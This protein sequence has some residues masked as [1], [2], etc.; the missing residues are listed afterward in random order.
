MYLVTAANKTIERTKEMKNWQKN[1]TKTNN[2]VRTKCHTN[3]SN[4]PL[5]MISITDFTVNMPLTYIQFDN[6]ELFFQMISNRSNTFCRWIKLK[7]RTRDRHKHQTEME[8]CQTYYRITWSLNFLRSRF[9]GVN[10]IN[11]F[12]CNFYPPPPD[13]DSAKSCLNWLSFLRYRDLRA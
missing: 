6:I 10:F 2:F 4:F 9:S 11:M 3:I 7:T 8:K 1:K 5:L 12:R 13:L